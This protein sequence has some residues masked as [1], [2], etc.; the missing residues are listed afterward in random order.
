MKIKTNLVLGL[1]ATGLLMGGLTTT[2]AQAKT[3]TPKLNV[4]QTTVGNQTTITVN[5]K[6]YSR[7]KAI[8]LGLIE[9]P[10]G[11]IK[12]NRYA[13]G[14]T[15]LK[16]QRTKSGKKVKVTGKL[17]V[18]NLSI[19]Q[20][21]HPSVVAVQVGSRRTYAKLTKHLT[22]SKT[23]TTK[24]KKLHLTAENY[25]HVK[26]QSGKALITLSGRK[27]VTVKPYK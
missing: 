5:G 18:T 26:G 19:G 12:A 17:V 3:T 13:Y 27:A 9:D 6:A 4:T 7:T 14:F 15:K 24:A 20:F 21:N 23:L 16:A 25:T 2:A 1:V 10:T 11:K 8:K 22:F